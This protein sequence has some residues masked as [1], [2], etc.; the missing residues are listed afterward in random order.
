[1]NLAA[2]ASILAL[3]LA[4]E[5]TPPAVGRPSEPRS[6]A[7]FRPSKHGFAFV[8]SFEGSP[9]AIGGIEL[10]GVGPSSYGIC[11]GMSAAAADFFTAG[12]PV[13]TRAEAPRRPEPLFAYL[14]RRQLDSL[15]QGLAQAARFSRWMGYPDDTAAGTML[16]SLGEL[17]TI[18]AGLAEGRGVPIGLVLVKRGGS[19]RGAV[20]DNHQV[21]AFAWA[22]TT[23]RTGGVD[24]RIYDP[25]HPRNDSVVLRCQPVI[26]GVEPSP[27]GL[28]VPVIG[29]SIR[30]VVSPTRTAP[31]RGIFA[32]P[33]S[34]ARP[35]EN[36]R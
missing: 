18:V 17:A 25:N 15:G 12:R 16:L 9:V 14:S 6:F 4:A 35:P 21:L 34:P 2:A 27:L 22:P 1:M 36:L 5:P 10:P 30:L 26:V 29:A 3:A 13:P 23:A 20:W 24:L 11:G 31:V 33:Y 8:N 28:S 7:E 32:M 19:R